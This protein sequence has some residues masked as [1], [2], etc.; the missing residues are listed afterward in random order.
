VGGIAVWQQSALAQAP[1]KTAIFSGYQTVAVRL[2]RVVART[3]P[4]RCKAWHFG[5]QW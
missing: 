1:E 5:A 4:E 2:I 3:T